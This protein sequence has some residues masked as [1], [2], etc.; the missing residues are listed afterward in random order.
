M[1]FC[2]I[3][4]KR[5]I[6]YK[7]S[8]KTIEIQ[9]EIESTQQQQKQQQQQEPEQ[10]QSPPVEIEYSS[11]DDIASPELA[12]QDDS[13]PKA[14]DLDEEL[15]SE[16]EEEEEISS[17][18]HDYDSE[19]SVDDSDLLKRL[20]EKYGRLPQRDEPDDEDGE[21]EYD[22]DDEDIDPTWTSI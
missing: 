15:L 17:E 12:F 11:E 21:P 18:G 10:P 9:T 7:E 2:S 4:Q 3:P 8:I 14:Y 5:S 22:H 13:E 6:E 20:D 1:F 16:E 19:S